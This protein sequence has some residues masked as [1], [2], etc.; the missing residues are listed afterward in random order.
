MNHHT[1]TVLDYTKT[2]DIKILMHSG[3][4]HSD[5]ETQKEVIESE[6]L[7]KRNMATKRAKLTRLATKNREQRSVL[8][9]E[10]DTWAPK[11]KPYRRGQD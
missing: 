4:L 1:T 3:H 11:L 9:S 5:E 8:S 2:E 6:K 10:S 7:K